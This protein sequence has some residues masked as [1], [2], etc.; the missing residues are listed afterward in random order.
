MRNRLRLNGCR[1]GVALSFN[2]F[3]QGGCET[4]GIKC[5]EKF[6]KQSR[7]FPSKNRGLR[8][9]R[10]AQQSKAE[11]KTT[12]MLRS[13]GSIALPSEDCLTDWYVS[14]KLAFLRK[15]SH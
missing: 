9:L 2:S 10:V 5:H 8:Q 3:E 7:S 11:S 6:S 12:R 1:G 14:C 4:Q 13:V 15:I